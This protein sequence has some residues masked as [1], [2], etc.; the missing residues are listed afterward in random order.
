MDGSAQQENREKGQQRHGL[1]GQ[2]VGCRGPEGFGGGPKAQ[3][4]IPGEGLAKN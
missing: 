4:P 3:G 2:S 1:R